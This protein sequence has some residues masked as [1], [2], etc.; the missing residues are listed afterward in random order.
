MASRCTDAGSNRGEFDPNEAPKQ[1]GGAL[2]ETRHSQEHLEPMARLNMKQAVTT[3]AMLL[4]LVTP[5]SA[6]GQGTSAASWRDLTL[7]DVGAAHGIIARN[8]PAAVV[9]AGDSAFRQR[10]ETARAAAQGRARDV[11]S[12]EGWLATLRAFAVA[13]DDPHISLGPRLSLGTVRWPGFV[14]ARR[15]DSTVV[16]SRDTSDATLPAAGTALVS[17][18]GVP[19]D[20]FSRERLGV[21][22]GTWE[23]A[24]QRVRNTPFLLVDD[25]NPFVTAPRAC[26]AREGGRDR[27][28]PLRWRS[29]ATTALQERLRDASPV[30]AAGF[31][32]RRSGDGWWIG[33]QSL[34]GR[35]QEVLDSAAAHAAELRAAPWVVVDVRGNGGGNSEWG[36]RLAVLLVG[37]PRTNGA[38]A[39]GDRQ[40]A[41]GLCGTSWRASAD[42]EQT[43][44]G[45]IKDMGPRVGEASTNQWRRELDSIRVARQ[46]GRELA[47]APRSCV[48]ATSIATRTLPPSLMNGR[49]VLLT[50]HAC[51]SSCLMLAALFRA[52]GA[53]HVGEGTDFSTRYMEVR[54]FPLPSGLGT[55]ATLQKAAFG[56]SPRL[57]P[58]EPERSY[59]GRMDDTRGLEEWIAR[60]VQ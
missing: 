27:E 34:G 14:V 39:V 51:F 50:D 12:Y 48:P 59:T 22:R 31:A 36:T 20:Q 44:E 30:G 41:S 42:V 40:L 5:R 3:A 9:A 56:M 28:I 6:P 46:Q 13:F 1:N 15:G 47:P 52:V 24:S 26:V 25:G 11:V 43:L 8:H 49:L 37:Q 32:V 54:G 35:V 38:M 29:V 21:F 53:L 58:F 4:I 33:I 19:I 23:V 10:L 2:D 17:C 57:G 45:Y 60:I 7:A 16:A 18:D 55:F